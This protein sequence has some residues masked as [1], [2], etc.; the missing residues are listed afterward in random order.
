MS[1]MDSNTKIG[2][3]LVRK[4]IA[5]F[6][7]VCILSNMLPSGINAAEELKEIHITGD[8]V[9]FQVA[10]NRA[11]G[12][13]YVSIAADEKGTI[14][15][16]TYKYLNVTNDY[17][18]SWV[19]YRLPTDAM[20]RILYD[21][22]RFYMAN[23]HVD[24]RYSNIHAYTSTDGKEW[25]SFDLDNDNSNHNSN[26]YTIVNVQYI[27]GQYILLAHTYNNETK[28]FTSSNGMDWYEKVEIP[29]EIYFITWNGTIYSAFG[30][31]YTF[32]SMSKPNSRN[33]LVVDA[34]QNRYAEMLI[35]SSND[36]KN[37]TMQSGS[38]KSNLKYS[39]VF[40][41]L[42][43]NNYYYDL[44]KPV[45]DGIITLYDSSGNRLIS[46]N[47][48][49]FT[50]QSFKKTLDA[51]YSRSPMFKVGKNYMIFAQYWFSPGVIRSKVLTSTDQV[52]WKTT[53]LTKSIPN[54]MTVIQA[55]SKL[56]GY[57][58]KGE[59]SISNDGFQWTKI[60]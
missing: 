52:H 46:K 7:L 27:N 44:E 16:V 60:R 9:Q 32:Y 41:G 24:Q 33:Q 5:I 17:G 37:W 38:I 11:T 45:F 39:F 36:L 2:V 59:M 26:P 30:G 50:V 42:P 13:D 4:Y 20:Y 40:N 8:P 18:K 10:F 53:N 19:S 28:L 29:S 43:R 56:I 47:G 6:V 58:D 25:F 22:G 48:T 21:K 15:V 55:G 23:M 54:T 51:N 31:G 3:R 12:D 1:Q 49:T 35:Y 57:G 14:I 34:A